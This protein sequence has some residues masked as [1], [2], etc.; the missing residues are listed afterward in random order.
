MVQ[1]LNGLT[2]RSHPSFSSRAFT[3]IELVVVFGLII[4]L[5]GLILSTAGYARKKGARVRAETEIAALS[6]ACENYKA[7]NGVH[8]RDPTPS[9]TTERSIPDVPIRQMQTQRLRS[10]ECQLLSRSI[11]RQKSKRAVTAADRKYNSMARQRV[12]R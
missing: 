9:T 2:L 10:S 8:P 3:I 4:V 7:D 1:R 6:A 11:R 12:H 5:T